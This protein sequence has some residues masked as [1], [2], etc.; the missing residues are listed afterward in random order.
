MPRQQ[1]Y[2]LN[3]RQKDE[4]RR[5]TQLANRRI[6]AAERAY[7]KEGKRVLP[8]EVVGPY[9]IKER[10]ATEKTPISRSVKFRTKEEYLRQLRFLRSFEHERPGIREYTR[11]QRQK[12]L[13]AV[14]TSLGT[15]VPKELE[16]RIK[17]M[18]APQ[19]SDFWNTFSEKASK[20]GIQYSSQQA[21]EDTL[22]EVFPE[23]I[24][25]LL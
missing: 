8:R 18:S 12:T 6:R 3:E 22:N 9:Q 24:E 25:Q 2:R 15:D 19:L 17:N 13:E 11:V 5:L 14:Q 21:M 10:W 16:E 4:I 20:M 23:D 7:R 1:Y